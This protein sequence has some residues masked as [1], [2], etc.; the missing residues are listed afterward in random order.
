M[1]I[2]TVL[3]Y[4]GAKWK[5]WEQIKPLI[6]RDIKDWR[7]PFL[8][9]GSI[10]LLVADD[11]EFNLERMVVGDLASEVWAFW[12]GCKLYADEVV[13]KVE[14]IYK[15][16]CVNK[17]RL[18]EMSKTD[19]EYNKVYEL[20]LDEGR[21]LWEWC[22]NVDISQM[23]LVERAA[24]MFI[25]NRISF[26]A[27]GDSGTLSVDNYLGFRLDKTERI[28]QAQPLLQKMEIL[29]CSFEYTMADVDKDKTFIFLD[30]PYMNQ[31]K[32]GLYG[33]NGNT[34]KGF[35]HEKLASLLKEIPCRWLMTYD[36][37]IGVRRLYRDFYIKPFKIV[38]TMAMRPAEDAL[39]GEEV[40]IANYNINDK[41][42]NI[43]DLL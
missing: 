4:P 41:V 5:A 13:K 28:L 38:Y 22:R 21:R 16:I 1:A 33:V 20:A 29:N 26:S 42:D 43:Y 3:R 9:G 31:E 15:G 27:M 6:P 37:S 35:P 11:I 24:R 25:V 34:H 30:P 19:E 14:E 23:N 12:Q 18:D 10:S 36:D 8:G 17:M 2:Q 39:A 40:F 32:S 7:E